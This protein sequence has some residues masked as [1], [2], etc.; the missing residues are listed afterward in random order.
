MKATKIFI[1][2]LA[3]AIKPL[4]KEETLIRKLHA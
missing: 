2:L 1:A 3:V 4:T